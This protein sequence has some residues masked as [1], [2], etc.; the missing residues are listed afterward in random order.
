MENTGRVS[1]SEF[2]DLSLDEISRCEE[3]YYLEL[4]GNIFTILSIDI[5]NIFLF[6]F[7]K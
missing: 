1:S 6:F 4:Y 3:D 2:D 7:Y 5:Y